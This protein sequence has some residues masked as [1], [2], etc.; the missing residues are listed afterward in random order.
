MDLETAHGDLVL[1]TRGRGL[2]AFH[3][4]AA[5][6]M[7]LRGRSDQAQLATPAPATR[8][9]R[10]QRWGEDNGSSNPPYG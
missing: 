1:G 4:L 7:A 6:R 10:D 3:D 9:R 8:W 2:Y 5:L